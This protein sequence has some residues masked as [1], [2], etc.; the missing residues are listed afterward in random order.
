MEDPNLWKLVVAAVTIGLGHTILGP[1]HYVPFIAMARARSWSLVRTL[2]ITVVCGIGHVGSSVVIGAVG[3]AVGW[4]VGGMEAFEGVR[5]GLAGWLLLG[6]GLA[7]M[8]WGIWR[9]L[10]NR[11]HTHAHL[12]A[13][14]IEHVHD[15]GHTG[16]HAHVH[17]AEQPVQTITPWVLFTIFVLGPCEPLIPLLMVPAAGQSWLAVLVVA[18]VFSLCTLGAMTAVVVVG[19]YGLSRLALPGLARYSHAL[20]GFAL[21]ACGAAIKLGL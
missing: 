20:A 13:D 8:V 5:G 1:D 4:A 2:V 10:K 3:I 16:E 6:F 9:A 15:H 19:Y 12:H 21:F 14:G 7:Y 11:P 17:H 18:L